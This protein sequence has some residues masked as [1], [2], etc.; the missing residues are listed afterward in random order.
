MKTRDELKNYLNALIARKPTAFT[1][2]LEM[3]SEHEWYEALLEYVP[4]VLK[5]DPRYKLKTLM[6]CMT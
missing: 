3:E 6:Y 1:R 5:E 2:W 4:A